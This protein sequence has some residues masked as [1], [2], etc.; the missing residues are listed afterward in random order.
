MGIIEKNIYL[1]TSEKLSD[2]NAFIVS[3]CPAS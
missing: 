3:Y 1:I 2:F